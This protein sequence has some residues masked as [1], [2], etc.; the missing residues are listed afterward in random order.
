MEISGRLLEWYDENKRNFPFRG[1]ADPYRIWVSE[2][3]LQQTGTETVVPYYRRFLEKYPD[4]MSLARARDDDVMKLWEGLGY[5]SRARNMLACAR[6]VTEKYGGEL[7]RSA[8]EL[9][10][11]P[12]IGAYTAAAVASIAFGERI[13]ALDGNLK[14]VFARLY[15]IRDSI[16]RPDVTRRLYDLA[17]QSIPQDRPGDMN[18]AL[19]DLGATVCV[20]GTPDCARCPLHTLCRAGDEAG[21]LPVRDKKTPQTTE[22][23]FVCLC[24][25]PDGRIAVTRREAG[26]LRGLALF[27]VC[28]KGPE[29]CP[30]PEK[31]QAGCKVLTAAR[32]VFTHRIW[33]M[34]VCHMPYE[35]ETGTVRRQKVIWIPAGE[36]DALAFPSAMRVPLKEARRILDR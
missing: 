17:L 20:P 22:T 36:L 29:E 12:G 30:P 14:R 34:T 18:Q 25:L 5:Y 10:K 11:L 6:L 8:A 13:P 4:L 31:D 16:D 3:M 21:T 9:E 24:T 23:L 32:H 35:R 28:Q 33:E 19:M 7:P 15:G 27:P 1:T 2:I 26:L